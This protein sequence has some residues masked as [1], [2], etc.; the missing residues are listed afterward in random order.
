MWRHFAHAIRHDAPVECSLE[1]G[2]RT[3]QVLLAIVESTSRGQPVRVAE[4]A[5]GV[6]PRAAR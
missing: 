1:D 6:T 4:A 2:R 5:R 3:L